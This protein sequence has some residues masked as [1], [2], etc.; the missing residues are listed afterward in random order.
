M[1]KIFNKSILFTIIKRF[2]FL[3][4][5]DLKVINILLIFQL[6]F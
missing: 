3:K 1:T 4:S 5:E 6:T 2:K